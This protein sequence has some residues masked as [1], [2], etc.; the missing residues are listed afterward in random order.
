MIEPLQIALIIPKFIEATLF[1]IVSIKLIKKFPNIPFRERPLLNA[2]FL[3]GLFSWFIYI[4]LDIVIFII[5]PLSLESSLPFGI[6]SG[7]QAEY[8]SLFIA[9]LIR[10]IGFL[11]LILISWCY[12]IAAFSIKYGEN[13]TKQIFFKNKMVLGFMIAFTL[14]FD[15]FDKIMV[16]YEDSR[17]NISSDWRGITGILLAIVIS[18]FIFAAIL[19]NTTLES[20]VIEH[21]DRQYRK[22][23]RLL[24][25]G[26]IFMALGDIYWL[27]LGL[28]RNW[29]VFLEFAKFDMSYEIFY[30]FGHMIWMLSPI[31]I[32]FGL[33]E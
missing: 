6:Y 20:T 14:I 3:I 16:T 32:Y 8:P 30:W 31:F 24:K 18:L 27:I 22:K 1:L 13:K 21:Q 2:L 25:Y 5:A 33:K 15:F 9:N 4:T 29:P 26:I 10:D 19:L 28:L 17:I 7:Y 12:F 11:G 23:I